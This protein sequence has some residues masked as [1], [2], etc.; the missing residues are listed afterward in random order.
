M[1]FGISNFFKIFFQTWLLLGKNHPSLEEKLSCSNF[2]ITSI[3]NQLYYG[4]NVLNRSHASVSYVVSYHISILSC[5]HLDLRSSLNKS[6]LSRSPEKA[7]MLHQ[8]FFCTWLTASLPA[9]RF[10]FYIKNLSFLTQR[11]D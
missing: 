5:I 11:T 8:Y 6:S 9:I 7:K 1:I 4:K 3:I 10:F 2:Y